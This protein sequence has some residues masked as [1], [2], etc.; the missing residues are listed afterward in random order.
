MNC[1][2]AK[3]FLY[4]RALDEG[5]SAELD[6]HLASCADC[7][8][9]LADLELTHKL[10]RQG[11][12]EEEPPRRIAF[13][14]DKPAPSS[15]R[16]FDS[17][18]V[19]YNPLRFWQWSFAG[20]AALALLFAVLAVRRPAPAA[21]SDTFTRAE[22]EA[23]ISKSVAQAVNAAVNVS[24]QRQQAETAAV[25]QSAAQRMA[26]Q[27]HY[28]ESTQTQ[29]YRQTEQNRADLREVSAMIGSAQGVRQ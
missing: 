4:D 9:E 7:R 14:A 10:M 17:A 28:L 20:A 22:V 18:A 23:L 16:A 1:E 29:V 25:I 27:F 19:A 15:A 12:P 13:I 8:A 6:Q 3:P 26:E 21:S 11:L 2:Q 5:A 24:E